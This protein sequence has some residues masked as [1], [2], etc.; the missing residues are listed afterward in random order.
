MWLC[1]NLPRKP[2]RDIFRSDPLGFSGWGSRG[3]SI[4][5]HKRQNTV[6]TQNHPSIKRATVFRDVIIFWSIQHV[7]WVPAN[8]LEA[9]CWARDT[10]PALIQFTNQQLPKATWVL[11]WSCPRCFGG[12]DK[13]E[14]L[15]QISA[16]LS[17]EQFSN[18]DHLNYERQDTPQPTQTDKA[19]EVLLSKKSSALSLVCLLFSTKM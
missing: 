11:Y 8:T 5:I 19:D 9:P 7:Y 14:C 6:N 1:S 10:I 18:L 15:R 2:I 13:A 17:G 4:I 12:K 16:I 3:I